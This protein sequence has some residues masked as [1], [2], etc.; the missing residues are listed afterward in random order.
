VWL[1]RLPLLL[2]LLLQ[3]AGSGAS[4]VL[5][6]L[7][8]LGPVLLPV[9]LLLVALLLHGALAGCWGELPLLPSL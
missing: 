4:T 2:L 6:P 5:P 9:R 8:R 3:R 1:P 7:W